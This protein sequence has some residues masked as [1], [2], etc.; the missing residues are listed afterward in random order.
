MRE[1]MPSLVKTLPRW[2]STVGG[3]QLLA[4]VGAALRGGRA[5]EP[6]GATRIP[7]PPR[8]VIPQVARAAGLHERTHGQATKPDQRAQGG[9]GLLSESVRDELNRLRNENAELAFERELL[10]RAA[11]VWAKEAM[12]P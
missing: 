9:E 11:A 6:G 8:T 7:G 1:L 3:A 12:V 2:Y 10:M 4:G 5:A